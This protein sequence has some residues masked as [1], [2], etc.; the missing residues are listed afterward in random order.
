M[1]RFWEGI[2]KKNGRKIE[3]NKTDHGRVG[4]FL[5]NDKCLLPV[6]KKNLEDFFNNFS[7]FKWLFYVYYWD[8][9]IVGLLKNDKKWLTSECNFWF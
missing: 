3:K 6:E 5:V 1:V 7:E 4:Y 9:N 8:N 2:L